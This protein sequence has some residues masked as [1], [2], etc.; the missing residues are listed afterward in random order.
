MRN[1]KELTIG[2]I[3]R[4]AQLYP[5][6]SVVDL[7]KIFDIHPHVINKHFARPFGWYKGEKPKI[8]TQFEKK[9]IDKERRIKN[10]RHNLKRRG[11]IIARMSMEAFYTSKTNRAHIVESHAREYGFIFREL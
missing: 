2:E 11:Y 4:M 9:D 5:H 1:W 7:A 10:Y 3:E 6:T 8:Q